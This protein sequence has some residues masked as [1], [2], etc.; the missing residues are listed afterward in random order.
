MAPDYEKFWKLW[1]EGGINIPDAMQ[2]EGRTE[3]VRRHSVLWPVDELI[4]V[5]S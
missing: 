4:I 3:A 1:G 5:T 2:E